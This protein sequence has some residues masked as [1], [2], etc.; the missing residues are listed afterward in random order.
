VKR[1]CV[2]Y[3]EVF[4]VLSKSK[5]TVLLK[6][7]GLCGVIGPII[8]LSF[9]ALAIAYS[10][11]FNWVQ[12]ALSDL[13]VHEAAL[14]F[15]SGLIVGGV[16]TTI[17]AIGLMQI[18]RKHVLGF[19]GAS[20]LILS[21]ISLCAIGLFPESAGRIHLYVSISF[22]ALLAISLLI[23][24]AALV[25]TSSQRYLGLYSILTVVVAVMAAWAIPHK[26]AA[27]PE[28]IGSLAASAWSIVFGIKLFK[29]T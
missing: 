7:A 18:L 6:I 9:I 20:I 24:G 1:F 23:I 19:L 21:A 27:I 15:N 12:N 28:I 13:G 26:G 5:Q 14:I 11:W 29:T 3:S 22:F 4:W 8:S 17:F 16:L 2:L 10:P 25:R